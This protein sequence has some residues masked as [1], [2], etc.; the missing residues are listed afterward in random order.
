[1]EDDPETVNRLLQFFYTS[2]YDDCNDRHAHSSVLPH[3]PIKTLQS[4]IPSDSPTKMYLVTIKNFVRSIRS[5]TLRHI[6]SEIMIVVDGEEID[7]CR[8]ISMCPLTIE[9]VVSSEETANK[10]V[11][12]YHS[13][14]TNV[15]RKHLYAY[16]RTNQFLL[17]LGAHKP[18]DSQLQTL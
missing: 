3:D 10:I 9:I 15:S 1:M 12:W 11:R 2:D 18:H 16:F 6:H 14:I 13:T 7:A 8:I 4:S 17:C 5:K